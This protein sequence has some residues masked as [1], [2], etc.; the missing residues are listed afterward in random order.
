MLLSSDLHFWIIKGFLRA[1][2]P[3]QLWNVE[4]LLFLHLHPLASS[5]LHLFQQNA[6]ICLILLLGYSSQAFDL[7]PPISNV[8]FIGHPFY[9]R[10]CPSCRILPSPH[11]LQEDSGTLAFSVSLPTH[12]IMCVHVNENSPLWL[13]SFRECWR[14]IISALVNSVKNV[15]LKCQA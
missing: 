12:W 7:Y 14:K 15:L 4:V 1:I 2:I 3:W 13:K 6:D 5:S 9:N 10:K 11:F 8:L